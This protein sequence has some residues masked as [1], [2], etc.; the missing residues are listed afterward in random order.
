MTGTARDSLKDRARDNGYVMVLDQDPQAK[1]GDAQRL[2]V[3][4]QVPL[5][6][7]VLHARE[8]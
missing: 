3:D 2:P 6:S 5:N 4:D 8:F 7:Q 1:R